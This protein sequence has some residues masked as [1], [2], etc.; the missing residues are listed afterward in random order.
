MASHIF[1]RQMRPGDWVAMIAYDI[2][3]E[4]LVDFTQNAGEVM[5]ALRRLNYPA[6]RESNLYDTV[7]D[8]MDRLEEVDGK[9]AMVLV[10]SGLDTFSKNNLGQLLKAA[11]K[12]NVVIYPVSIGGNFRARY[13]NYLGATARL[14]FQQADNTLRTLAKYTGGQAYFPRFEAAYPG[15]FETISALLRS[16]Y[17]LSY[18]SSNPSRDEK[19][20][21]LKVV[22]E[23]DV[24]GDGKPDKLK[25][26][27]KEGYIPK[28][29]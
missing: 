3:P 29:S 28:I 13:D 2:R 23:A 10:S 22:V 17:T 20:R 15:I 11:R 24:N 21:K 18:V 27:H 26:R 5:Q 9:V 6:F 4:I 19:Y 12:T 8:T 25:V 1:A 7:I 14:D 16:Q